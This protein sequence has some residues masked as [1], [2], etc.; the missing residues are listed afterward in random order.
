MAVE[1]FQSLCVGS[2][3]GLPAILHTLRCGQAKERAMGV[4]MG[5][6]KPDG[7]MPSCRMVCQRGRWVLILSRRKRQMMIIQSVLPSRSVLI[8]P[9][10]PLFLSLHV[11]GRGKRTG[12]PKS[13]RQ[14]HGALF[15]FLM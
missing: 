10:R 2:Y 5:S 4:M 1:S 3:S 6:S 13:A 8:H 14:G 15:A 11:A 7:G 12:W 9:R